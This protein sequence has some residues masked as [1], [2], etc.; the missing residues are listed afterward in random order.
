[1]FHRLVGWTVFAVSHGIVCKDENRGKFHQRG[2]PDSGPRVI[3]E[4][5]EGRA[6]GA[7]FGKRKS[8]H[9]GGHRVLADTE[10][11]VLSTRALCLEVAR[12]LVGQSSFVRRSKVGRTAKKPGD[13]LC[14]HVQNFTRSVSPRNAFRVGWKKGEVAVPT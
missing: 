4:D 1:M 2:K 11:Q 6:E 9:D 13:I 12:A 8:V 3:A 5:E 10:M 14:E 7:E